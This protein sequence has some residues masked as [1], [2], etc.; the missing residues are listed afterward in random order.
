MRARIALAYAGI[1]FEIR[2]V[3]LRAKPPSLL[4]LSAKATVPVMR[5]DDRVLEQSLDIMN[6][7][8]EQQDPDGWLDY[9]EATLARMILLVEDCDQDFKPNLDRYKYADRHAELSQQ[10]HRALA[11]AFISRLDAQ[12]SIQQASENAYLFGPKP[13]YADVAVLPFVRQF[14][15]VDIEWFKTSPYTAL[16]GWLDHFLTSELFRA[17]MKKYP[18]WQEGDSPTYFANP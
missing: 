16:A 12:L 17:V 14:A 6:W 11:E 13:G 2:E 4:E 18:A 9:D 7:A 15:Y 3:V 8:L 1:N 5:L 10:Q